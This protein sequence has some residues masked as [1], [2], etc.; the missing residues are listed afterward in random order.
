MFLEDIRLWAKNF[1]EGY[2]LLL[3]FVILFGAILVLLSTIFFKK[4]TQNNIFHTNILLGISFVFLVGNFANWY[5]IF[6]QNKNISWQNGILF[7]TTNLAKVQM[8]M[9]V[10]TIFALTTFKYDQ[11]KKYAITEYLVGWFMILLGGQIAISTTHFLILYLAFELM[12]IGA[13]MLS[14][15]TF[16]QN[17]AQNS[18]KYLLFGT[19]TT[20]VMLYGISWIYGLTG[21]LEYHF[22]EKLPHNETA[23]FAIIFLITGFLLKISA[24]PTHFWTA[25]IYETAPI[26]LVA[27]I[28]NIPKIAG[29]FAFLGWWSY[30]TPDIFLLKFLALL[31]IITLSFG[32]FM[33]MNSENVRRMFA[34]STIAHAG[35]L[36][37]P[38]LFVPQI[39]LNFQK[40]LIFEVLFF[41]TLCYA[42]ANVGVWIGIILLK[43][44]NFDTENPT[45]ETFAGMGKRYPVRAVAFCVLMLALA[46]LPP[47]A[48]FWGKFLIFS[49]IWQLVQSNLQNNLGN[50]F[51]IFI[52]LVS[53]LNTIV[54]LGYYFKLPYYLFFKNP[55][56]PPIPKGETNANG[57]AVLNNL[58]TEIVFYVC[59]LAMLVLFF[60]VTL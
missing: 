22:L 5:F 51:W 16:T 53:I 20:A 4:I 1:G 38:L 23:F 12:S 30:F 32:N 6:F 59:V 18:L 15:Y 40:N 28:S 47:T 25:E 10:M 13:Y 44:P 56:S 24:I 11:I 21:G 36:L 27:F 50:N 7:S 9:S 55:K 52:F 3:P 35:F 2:A 43:N 33:A 8:L 54:A 49:G 34:F 37:F 31:A 45:F 48:V 17:S 19:F 14:A 60:K 41:Y 46:G 57:K 39:S 42:V 29:I 58:I 26:S